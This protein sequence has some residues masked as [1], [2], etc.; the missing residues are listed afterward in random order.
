MFLDNWV[1]FGTVLLDLRD[2]E[3]YILKAAAVKKW[4]KYIKL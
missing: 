1:N 3:E 2:V 4:S